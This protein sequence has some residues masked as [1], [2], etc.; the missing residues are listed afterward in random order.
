MSDFQKDLEE[1]RKIREAKYLKSTIVQNQ[2]PVYN[3]AYRKDTLDYLKK[4]SKLESMRER[5]DKIEKSELKS[6][7]SKIQLEDLEYLSVM[8][9][10]EYFITELYK[11]NFNL[12]VLYAIFDKTKFVNFSIIK[13]VL[14]KPKV[15]ETFALEIIKTYTLTNANKNL[16]QLI[17]TTNLLDSK[18]T[19]IIDYV[20]EL[21]YNQANTPSISYEQLK[22][23]CS[24][25]QITPDKL[26]F[27]ITI[28]SN[29]S[30]YSKCEK[31]GIERT[32]IVLLKNLIRDT[33]TKFKCKID[34]D[35]Y[36]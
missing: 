8:E 36:N 24:K 18:F 9:L 13:D 26:K 1:I 3:Y 23:I 33:E 19:T 5:M 10:N 20:M 34:V 29:K 17:T 4:V 2:T 35:L 22:F 31:T 30:G 11:N 14:T 16:T 6:K 28:C 7:F 32:N 21:F 12:P 25:T 27:L 15:S